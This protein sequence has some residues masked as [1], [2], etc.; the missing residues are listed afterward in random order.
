MVH[1][2]EQKGSKNGEDNTPTVSS[3]TG[4]LVTCLGYPGKWGEYKQISVHILPPRNREMQV[5]ESRQVI[6]FFKT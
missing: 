3:E 4:L 2:F 1:L 5:P 6:T